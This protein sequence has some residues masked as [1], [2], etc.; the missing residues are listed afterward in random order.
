MH[1]SNFRQSAPRGFLVVSFQ[2]PPPQ[3]PPL[4]RA[5]FASHPQ[6]GAEHLQ[7]VPRRGENPLSPKKSPCHWSAWFGLLWTLGKTQMRGCMQVILWTDKIH[8][9]PPKKPR[10][11]SITLEIP[12]QTCGFNHGFISC[13]SNFGFGSRKGGSVLCWVLPTALP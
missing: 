12:K 3:P 9:A 6:T 4:S 13:V 5:A 2:P 11:D 8:F 10:N 7:A 1:S